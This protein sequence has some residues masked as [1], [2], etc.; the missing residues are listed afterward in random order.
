V[1]QV[2]AFDAL[3]KRRELV[4]VLRVRRVVRSGRT[5]HHEHRV[6]ATPRSAAVAAMA[7]SIRLRRVS[8]REA[9]GADRRVEVETLGQ[10]RSGR[11]EPSAAAMSTPFGTTATPHA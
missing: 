9:R 1:Q 7:A 8:G 3:R 6:V 11:R 4:E 2:D 5:G 10:T